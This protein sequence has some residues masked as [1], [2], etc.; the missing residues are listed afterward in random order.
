[1]RDKRRHGKTVR[2]SEVDHLQAIRERLAKGAPIDVE[3]S[4]RHAVDYAVRIVA[5]MMQIPGARVVSPQQAQYARIVSA[6]TGAFAA[7][8][9][10]GHDPKLGCGPSGLLIVWGDGKTIEFPAHADDH[11]GLID[12]VLE[13][14]AAEHVI[15][16]SMETEATEES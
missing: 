8:V 13:S 6:A 7:L 14:L 5:G 3:V 16:Q 9:R 12:A 2:V 4:E 10:A 1:M 15:V 11:A